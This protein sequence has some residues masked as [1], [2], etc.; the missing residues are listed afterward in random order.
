MFAYYI[1]FKSELIQLSGDSYR[2]KHRKTIFE[3]QDNK[4]KTDQY[5]ES[6]QS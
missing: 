4:Y 1:L 3:K 2:M 6:E 5:N